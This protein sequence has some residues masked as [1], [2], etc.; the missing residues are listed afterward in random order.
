[1]ENSISDQRE[2][3]RYA[4]PDG[5]IAACHNTVCRITDISEG[6]MALNC[7]GKEPFS[8]EEKPTILCRTKGFF[9]EDLPIRL[10][11]KTN[12]ALMPSST[13]QIETV[14]VRFDYKSA[15]QRNQIRAYISGLS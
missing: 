15:A 3:K 12:E 2:H 1:M 8:E 10:V 7:I 5:A 11:R 9:I 4:A 13:F 14:G 6:G